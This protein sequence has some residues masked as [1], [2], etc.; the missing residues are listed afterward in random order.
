[1]SKNTSVENGAPNRSWSGND[2]LILA[3][4]FIPAAIV[5]WGIHEFAHWLT[6]GVLGYDMWISFNQ[7]GLV[8]G[9]YD[10]KLH[11][12]LVAMAG[13]FVTWIQAVVTLIFIFRFRQLW[14]YSFLFLTLWSRALA[15]GISYI[16]NPNDEAGASLLVGLPMWVLPALSVIFLFVLTFLGSRRLKAGWKGNLLAY[17]MASIVTAVIVFS[18]QILFTAR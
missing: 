4:S 7:V 3:L 14:I 18:D 11:E 8:E 9:K 1:M 2:Y 12:F 15:F 16:S 5:S 6:G 17:L 10:S 13:P